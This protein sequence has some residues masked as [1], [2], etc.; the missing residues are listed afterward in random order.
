MKARMGFVVMLTL[1]VVGLAVTADYSY[2]PPSGTVFNPRARSDINVAECIYAQNSPDPDFYI[3]W[4]RWI[5]AHTDA[6]GF[7]IRPTEITMLDLPFLDIFLSDTPMTALWHQI[8]YFGAI[9]KF[10]TLE[11]LRGWS[12]TTTRA[13]YSGE[14]ALSERE[15][16]Q[17]GFM[18]DLEMGTYDDDGQFLTPIGWPFY[19]G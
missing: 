10:Q 9:K 18:F 11:A 5:D 3:T 6:N 14:D 15:C 13:N 7:M 12:M 16:I 19:D 4:A 8:H 17:I 2:T 1:M